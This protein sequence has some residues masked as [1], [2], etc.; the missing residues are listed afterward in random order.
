M[1]LAAVCVERLAELLLAR[2]HRAWAVSHGAVESGA[3]H[4]PVMVGLHAAL[5][6]GCAVEPVLRRGGRPRV[7][8][9]RPRVG[10]DPGVQL[11]VGGA[12]LAAQALRW[13][14]IATLGRRWNTR[15]LVLPG[16]PPVDSGPYR[17]L[18]H[19]NYLAVAVEGAALPIAC[20][21]P[22]TAV[23]FTLAD[24]AL[25]TVRIRAENMALADGRVSAPPA[26][27]GGDR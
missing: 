23:A 24:A 21:A 13:W 9:G 11:V 7:G 26:T 20:G 17:W 19:P 27:R 14:C 6:A 25:L 1:L 3:G 8:P 16:L 2:R 12:V 4:Y 5:L 18:A 22:V 10:L 15:I